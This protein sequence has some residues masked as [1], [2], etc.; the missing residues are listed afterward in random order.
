MLVLDLHP[1]RDRYVILETPVGDVI[2]EVTRV[3]P[4]RRVRVSFDAPSSVRI[5]RGNSRRECRE[6]LREE[7]P[8]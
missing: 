1:N 6:R 2:L 5:A 7:S 8:R 4:S 3:A